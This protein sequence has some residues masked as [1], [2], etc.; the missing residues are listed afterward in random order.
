MLHMPEPEWIACDQGGSVSAMDAI[1][2][3]FVRFATANPKLRFKIGNQ[4]PPSSNHM[5]RT[6]ALLKLRAGSPD[7]DVLEAVDGAVN[8][9]LN[10]ETMI[11]AA[12]RNKNGLNLAACEESSAVKMLGA[13][14]EEIISARH[15][16]ELGQE[17]DWI[18]A[19]LIVTSHTWE[20]GKGGQ[21]HQDPTIGE[22]L[23]G[24]MSDVSRVL[25][26]PDANTAVEALRSICSARGQIGCIVVPE[27]P[28]PVVLGSTP[29][30]SL[31]EIGA[32]IVAGEA[33]SADVQLVAIWRLSA[34]RIAQGRR[35]VD[36]AQ[37]SYIACNRH[38][39]RPLARAPRQARGR[40]HHFGPCYS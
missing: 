18:G 31:F 38:R 19:P 2:A 14:R 34:A 29:A 6:L 32:A 36:R 5:H 1:D 33:R 10:V 12:L 40:S 20:N 11:G 26:P 8:T 21:S 35:P 3:F 37:D 15:Q 23:L 24:E 28:V 16:R 22:V 17:P 25:F 9:D 13:L 4:Y 7:A 39:T 30:K 27:L